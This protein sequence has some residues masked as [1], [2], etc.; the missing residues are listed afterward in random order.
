MTYSWMLA[1]F[2]LGPYRERALLCSSTQNAWIINV[3]NIQAEVIKKCD[4]IKFELELYLGR[5]HKRYELGI[6]MIKTA[7]THWMIDNGS[8]LRA[9]PTEK[10]RWTSI[11]RQKLFQAVE[12]SNLK[13]N[14]KFICIP[15][16]NSL[17]AKSR[18][19]DRVSFFVR[20]K[21]LDLHFPNSL[22]QG[23]AL[24][25]YQLDLKAK[26]NDLEPVWKINQNGRGTT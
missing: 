12:D 6:W 17:R 11:R 13:T 7:R 4:S 20:C 26:N 3:I 18:T 24:L 16:S 21:V 22:C 2:S 9:I 25:Q 5:M 1:A 15:H 23:S 19:M 10:M 14:K 8:L